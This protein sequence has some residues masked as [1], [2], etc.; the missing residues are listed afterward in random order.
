MCTRND[1]THPITH[2]PPDPPQLH[3]ISPSFV[4]TD[5]D[6]R[7]PEEQEEEEDPNKDDKPRLCCSLWAS[8][9]FMVSGDRLCVREDK[10]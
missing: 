9:G 4:T 6:M 3:C 8:V 10:H 1:P 5:F 2:T 7:L